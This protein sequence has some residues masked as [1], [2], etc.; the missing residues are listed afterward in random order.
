MTHH[1]TGAVIS[2]AALPTIAVLLLAAATDASKEVSAADAPQPTPRALDGHPDLSGSWVGRTGSVFVLNYPQNHEANGSINVGLYDPASGTGFRIGQKRSANDQ[3]TR[4]PGSGDAPV[5][6]DPANQQKAEQLYQNGSK[7]DQVVA[8]AQPGVPRV[9]APNKIIQTPSEVVFLY[10]DLSGMVWRVVPTDG[11]TFRARVDPSYYGDA[12]GHWDG[13]TLV[14]ET[15]NFTTETWFGEY[16]YFHSA[17]MSVI[18]RL[19]RSGDNLTWQ[20]TVYD[21]VMLAQP[22]AKPPLVLK[23]TNEQIEEPLKCAPVD[24]GFDPGHHEQRVP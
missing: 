12:V 15:H 3:A 21:P 13:D 18:E 20:A 10:S 8:C 2:A 23:K 16:G 22:W 17:Q 24:Y 1:W 6:K 5:Y 19:S 11:R 14:V 9:G 4:Q 7:T